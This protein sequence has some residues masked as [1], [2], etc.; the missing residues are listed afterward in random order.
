MTP[1]DIVKI[2]DVFAKLL[3][4]AYEERDYW[5]RMYDEQSRHEDFYEELMQ[6]KKLAASLKAELELVRQRNYDA[7]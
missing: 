2:A 3:E 1:N 4:N 5:H 7:G 6:Y